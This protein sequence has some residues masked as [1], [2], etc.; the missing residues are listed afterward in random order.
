MDEDSAMK[1]RNQA[2]DGDAD[3]SRWGGGAIFGYCLAIEKHSQSLQS[4]AF[5]AKGSI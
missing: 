4:A 1:P 5:A 2:L 3:V